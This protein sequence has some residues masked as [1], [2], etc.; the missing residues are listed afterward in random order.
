MIRVSY[1]FKS[2]QIFP[3]FSLGAAHDGTGNGCLADDKYVMAPS[4]GGVTD[5]RA[6]NH[7]TFSSCSVSYFEQLITDLDL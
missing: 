2:L 4:V 5:S 7:Y 6:T 3:L 1:L